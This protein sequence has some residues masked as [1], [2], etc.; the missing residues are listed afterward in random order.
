MV[1]RGNPSITDKLGDN[2][3]VNTTMAEF[4]VTDIIPCP[5]PSPLFPSDS[6][7]LYKNAQNVSLIMGILGGLMWFL[8]TNFEDEGSEYSADK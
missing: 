1:P 8:E 4:P 6:V 3:C 5:S 2:S 7:S